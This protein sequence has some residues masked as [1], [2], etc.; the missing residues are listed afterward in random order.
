VVVGLSGKG[1]GRLPASYLGLSFESG[2]TVNSGLLD[3]A[4]NLPRLLENLGPGV[5]R[6]GGQSVDRT[7]SGASRSALSGLARLV[8]A[9]GWTVI[10][11]VNLGHFNAARVTADA[12]GVAR[13][14]GRHLLEIACGNEPDDYA[15]KGIRPATY[16]ETDYLS[17]V[18]ACIHAVRAGAPGV[19]I[20]G[21]DTFH[22]NWLA[23]YAAAEKGTVSLLAEH[24]YSMNNCHGQAGTGAT[25]LSSATA[26]RE[27]AAIGAA[28]AAAR[29]ARVP[30][31][32]TETNSANCGGI[33]G[34]SNAYAAALWAANYLLTGAE[35]GASGMN[36]HGSLSTRCNGYTPLCQVG[37]RKFAAQPVYYG[38]LFTHLLGTGTLLRVSSSGNIAAHAIRGGSGT[39][40]VLIENFSASAARIS[41][42]VSGVSG[43]ATALYLTGPSLTATSGIRIQGARVQPD[44]A[45]KPGAASRLA[46]RSGTCV[47]TMAALS[48]V[49]V[50]LPGHPR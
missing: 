35:H 10:Y 1:A 8:R 36:F 3:T 43:T 34:V 15:H 45:F 50:T 14:L 21:P 2:S 41:L 16:T 22:V 6:F 26:A 47:V 20:A 38:M 23:S 4:G 27:A 5:L 42:R 29:I 13:Y 48:A 9:T 7:Y 25:L 12:A 11:T 40:R 49:I 18:R 44:G 19:H 30:L 46:C 28:A 31:R 24:L 33:K 37:T 39:V 32:M 17:E